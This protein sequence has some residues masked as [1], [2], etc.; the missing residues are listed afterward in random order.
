MDKFALTLLCLCLCAGCTDQHAPA[1]RV[2]SEGS[3][4]AKEVAVTPFTSPS[5]WDLRTS[6]NPVSGEVTVVA[7]T[8][9]GIGHSFVLRRRGARLDCYVNTGEFLETV[10][11]M[12]SRI[13]TVRF[14]LDEGKPLR[15]GWTISDDNTALFCGNAR[16]VIGQIQ[17]AHSLAIEYQPADKVPQ[18]AVFDVSQLPAAF[19]A[20]R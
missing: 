1:V 8:D 14:K 5:P 13:S 10:D 16:V 20:K 11:N 2:A 9:D 17:K 7:A 19:A 15:Q 4:K 6:T 3:V 18:T 12:E